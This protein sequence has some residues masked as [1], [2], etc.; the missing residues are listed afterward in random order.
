[1]PNW[2]IGMVRDLSASSTGAENTASKVAENLRSLEQ[3]ADG[4]LRTS[5]AKAADDADTAARYARDVS[6]G[7]N[8]IW[9]RVAEIQKSLDS[10][11]EVKA[12]VSNLQLDVAELRRQLR[13]HVD[14]H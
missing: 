3:R 8:L 4:D 14:H 1:M 7:V 10:V 9:G 13:E 11:A 6:K 2:I 5:I 12:E